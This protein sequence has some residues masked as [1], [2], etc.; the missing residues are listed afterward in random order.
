M[1]TTGYLS[2]QAFSPLSSIPKSRSSAFMPRHCSQTA[3]QIEPVILSDMTAN[4]VGEMGGQGAGSDGHHRRTMWRVWCEHNSKCLII[5]SSVMRSIQYIALLPITFVFACFVFHINVTI[6]MAV[7][8]W[9]LSVFKYILHLDSETVHR[10]YVW[11]V[12]QVPPKAKAQ[13][14]NMARMSMQLPWKRQGGWASFYSGT[15]C[16]AEPDKP[17]ERG[18][19]NNSQI[20]KCKW[21][22]L[23]A[24]LLTDSLPS[25]HLIL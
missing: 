13:N 2:F 18:K 12:K 16:T 11:L 3:L 7:F 6:N 9:Q 22:S 25:N 14:P 21:E 8:L 4:M 1:D 20:I 10:N 23:V 24:L 5:L 17:K 19:N 15:T